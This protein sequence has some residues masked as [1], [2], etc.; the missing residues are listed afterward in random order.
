MSDQPTIDGGGAF[1]ERS[2]IIFLAFS[3]IMGTLL[4]QGLTLPPLIHVLGVDDTGPTANMPL[5]WSNPRRVPC[6]PIASR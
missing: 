1:P 6:P 4:I 2:E 3:V 5:G